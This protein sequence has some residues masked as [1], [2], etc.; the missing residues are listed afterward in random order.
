MTIT[1][2]QHLQKL[3]AGEK[4]DWVPNYEL[5]C[6]GQTV[7]RWYAEGMPGTHARVGTMDM[8]EGEDHFR[9][10]RRAFARLNPGMIPGFTPEVL[11]EDAETVTARHANGV[12]TRALKAGTVRGTRMSMDTYLSFPVTDWASWQDVRRRYRAG[13]P[14]RYPFWWDEQV[15]LWRDADY[16]VV[17]LGNGAFGL[18]SQL[19][20]WVGTEGISYLFYDD[21]ALVDEMLEFA[22]DFLLE[23]VEPALQ[24]VRFDYFNFFE[25]CA[26][27]GGPLFGPELFRKFFMKHYK[28]II[29]RLNRAGI[30]SIWVDSDGDCEVLLPLWLEAGVNCSWPLEQA[31]GMDPLRLRRRFGRDLVLAC[32]IDKREIAKG[33]AAIEKELL[34]RLP[35]LL[36]QGGYIPF[37]DHA[38][39]PDISYSDFQFYIDLK[40]KLM[41]RG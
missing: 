26:G 20:S 37:L 11:A 28:R 9:L 10:D 29:G 14:V 5:G 15:R 8:F 27:K 22:T 1:H 32:G 6:W 12:V 13:D 7:E 21:P 24:Q 17:L 18:Y 4:T 25:D 31:S 36:D 38:V 19:R 35:P 2:R 16:P 23:L 33:R 40:L 41:G 39:P 3:L 30:G 34:A